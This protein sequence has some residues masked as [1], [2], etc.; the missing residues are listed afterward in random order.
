[1]IHSSR[2][3]EVAPRPTLRLSNSVVMSS[4]SIPKLALLSIFWERTR[5]R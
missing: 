2:Q 3:W 5:T 1:M 4:W